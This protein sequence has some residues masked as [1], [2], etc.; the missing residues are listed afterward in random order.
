[1]NVAELWPRLIHHFDDRGYSLTICY[2]IE[3]GGDAQ[4]KT[5]GDFCFDYARQCL[6]SPYR[7]SLPTGVFLWRFRNPEELREWYKAQ[8]G[9]PLDELQ[10]EMTEW[11][12]GQLKKLD[13]I[14]VTEKATSNAKLQNQISELRKTRIP[15]VRGPFFKRGWANLYGPELA[16]VIRKRFNE[17]RTQF[18]PDSL[19]RHPR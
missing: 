15:V 13:H 7:Y 17:S 3:D 14:D 6:E 10:I 8:K 18:L 16:A 5:V 19:K 1:M 11:A 4:N 12:I 2:D 9:K